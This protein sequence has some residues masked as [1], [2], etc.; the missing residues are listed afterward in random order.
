[1]AARSEPPTHLKLEVGALRYRIPSVGIWSGTPTR[2]GSANAAFAEHVLESLPRGGETTV[3]LS[4]GGDSST[5]VDMIGFTEA[6]REF[7]TCRL[8]R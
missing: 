5:G 8:H 2:F 7:A 1:M 6:A 4:F 3:A